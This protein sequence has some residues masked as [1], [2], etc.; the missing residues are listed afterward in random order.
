MQNLELAKE[1]LTI[2]PDKDIQQE[3]GWDTL[4]PYDTSL[5]GKQRYADVLYKA[6]TK[7]GSTEMFFI[8]SHERKPDELLPVKVAEYVL[9]TVRKSVRQQQ[10]KPNFATGLSQEELE[11]LQKD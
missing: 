8:F 7:K 9:G 1:L 4:T 3:V 5:Q 6:L 10:E 2:Y 11:E